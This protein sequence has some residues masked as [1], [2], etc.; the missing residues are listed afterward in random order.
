MAR[1]LPSLSALRA[2]EAAARHLSFAKAADELHVT[3]AA[4]SH[5]IKA[6]EAE[7]GVRLFRRLNRAVLL[8]EAA[9]RCL[10]GIRDGFERLA[11]AMESV[12]AGQRRGMVTVSVAPSL[13]AK[14]L[15]PRLDRFRAR[16]TDIEV[17]I[18]AS[19]QIVDLEAEGVDVGIR[20]G[21]GRYPG[22]KVDRLF[23][24]EVS[25]VCSPALLKGPRALRKPED[26]RWH[27]LLHADWSTPSQVL[28]DWRMWLLAA[29]VEGVDWSKGPS[30][31]D[32]YLTIQAAMEGQGVALA[33]PIIVATDLAA[34]RLAQPFK[35][36]VSGGFAY[37][38]V[39]P[40]ASADAPKVTAFRDWLIEETARN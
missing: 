39:T 25:P 31:G 7:L 1:R 32:Y 29:H 30:Y 27:T 13:A 15:V 16:H 8:T 12:R 19:S 37:Y 9:Q 10:P 4:I 35:L 21:T 23:A 6:L 18:D 34:G 20:Y 3:P 17:R 26:L 33:S 24:E 5:R 11:Q 14:W 38:V 40:R 28:P 36:A 22:L 2:F